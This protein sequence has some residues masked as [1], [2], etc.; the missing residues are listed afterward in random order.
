MFLFF[1]HFLHLL[2]A[3]LS[4]SVVRIS[5]VGTRKYK[6]AEKSRENFYDIEPIPSFSRGH[7]GS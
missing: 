2:G 3:A 5:R 6:T 7:D 4:L 1:W